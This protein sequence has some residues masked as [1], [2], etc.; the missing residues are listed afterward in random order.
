MSSGYRL[1]GA[2]TSA[3]STKMRSYLRYKGVEHEWR[4]RTSDSEEELRAISKFATL[5]VLV[6]ASGFAVHDTTSTIEALEADSPEPSATPTDPALAFLAC[7]LEEYADTWLAK[8]VFHYRWTR[9]KDQRLAAQRAVD[10]YYTSDMPADRKAVEDAAILAMQGQLKAMGLEGDLGVVVEKSVKR[11]VK[12]LDDHLRT[13]RFVFGGMPTIADFAIAGQLIQLMK[14]P[15]PAKIIEKDGEFVA[16][17]CD[18]MAAPAAGG[19][20]ASLDELKPT[21][22]PLFAGELSAAFLPWAAE[23][24]ESSLAGAETFEVTLGRDVLNLAPLRSA[25]R[26][27]R[28]LRRK[29]VSGQSIEA[30]KAFTDETAA[31]VHLLRPPLADRP[32]REPREDRHRGAPRAEL[33]RAEVERAK[34]ESAEGEPAEGESIDENAEAGV[35]RAEAAPRKRRRR[36]RADMGPEGSA[37][38]MGEAAAEETDMETPDAPDREAPDVPVVLGRGD[39]PPPADLPEAEAD[40]VAGPEAGQTDDGD[41]DRPDEDDPRAAT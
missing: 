22:A 4:P 31:T 29:F 8:A 6:T 11:F 25:A 18:F 19:P 12:L 1:F 34:G 30:L 7:V 27:F 2:E 13:H 15:T 10:D 20:F 21:L 40:L 33:E 35:S 26:S 16:R 28:E 36:R 41:P 9:K 17:W 38:D 39:F 14:D 3:Y 5:P 24:L 23:N 32:G 37:T